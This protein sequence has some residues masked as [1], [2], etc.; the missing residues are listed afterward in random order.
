MGFLREH[1]AGVSIGSSPR[2]LTFD[3]PA[4]IDGVAGSAHAEP[5][6]PPQKPTPPKTR[7]ARCVP[8]LEPPPPP[9]HPTTQTHNNSCPRYTLPHNHLTHSTRNTRN[10]HTPTHTNTQQFMRTRHNT[11]HNT[12]QHN[13]HNTHHTTHSSSCAQ[14]TTHAHGPTTRWPEP[15][16]DPVA[17]PK[18]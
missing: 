16:S 3:Y 7:S 11:T 15:P 9:L 4:V 5:P 10:T 17:Q 1:T 12:T 18:R 8:P 14:N 6:P 13:T 2:G